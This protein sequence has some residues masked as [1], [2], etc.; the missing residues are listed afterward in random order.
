MASI[1]PS[2]KRVA[3]CHV[4]HPASGATHLDELGAPPTATHQ[5][6]VAAVAVLGR[7]TTSTREPRSTGVRKR[8]LKKLIPQKDEPELSTKNGNGDLKRRI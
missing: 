4:V 8:L 2:D 7:C 3:W 6:A 5:G 1:G